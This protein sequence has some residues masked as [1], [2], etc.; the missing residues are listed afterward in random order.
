MMNLQ[1]F[2]ITKVLARGWKL[3]I[4]VDPDGTGVQPAVWTPIKGLTSFGFSNGNSE[5]DTTDFESEG[6][7][8]HMIA[9]RNKNMSLEGHYLEDK[10]TKDRDAGQEAVE[11][12]A[13]LIGPESLGKFRLT[14]PAGT[15]TSFTA[16]ANVGEIGGGNNDSTKWSAA[17]K[18][19]GKTTVA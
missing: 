17:L 2:G 16:S 15:V 1:Q 5:V 12:L 11:A 6:S 9:S 14:S 10:V 4:E 19:S 7:E 13:E 18:I 3:E 8:E